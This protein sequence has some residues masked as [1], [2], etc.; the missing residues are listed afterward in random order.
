MSLNDKQ[1][2]LDQ[3]TGTERY[4]RWS[5]LFGRMVLTDGAKFVAENGGGNGA[6]W[7]MD[8]IASHQPKALK[9]EMLR[10]IQFWTLEVKEKNGRKSA[11]LT[12]R[13]DS[14]EKPVIT[15]RIEFTDFDL[16]KIDLWVEPL[17]ENT[18]VILLPSE[19]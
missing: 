12:C 6:F 17:D 18:Y 2:E 8:A 16:P 13:T 4:T 14:G 19:H 1:S 5:L 3:F 9:N 10:D 7:L 11:V 15:Q